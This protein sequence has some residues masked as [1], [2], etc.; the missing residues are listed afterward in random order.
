VTHD[1]RLE[2]WDTTAD[3]RL[4]NEALSGV[5]DLRALS[6]GCVTRVAGLTRLHDRSGKS[7]VLARSAQAIAVDDDAIL[8]STGSQVRRFSAAGEPRP[9]VDTG[10]GVVAM[11]RVGDRLLVGFRDGGIEFAGAESDFPTFSFEGTPASPVTVMAEG[12][13]G[14]V[15]VGYVN[16][17]LGIWSLSNGT[18]LYDTRLHGPVRHLRMRGPELQVATELGDHITL[19]VEV[20]QM[21]DC[22]LLQQVWERVPVVWRD[23]LP[24]PRPPPADHRCSRP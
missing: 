15:V 18:L 23:G 11:T 19:D 9:V 7:R 14:T 1:D 2:L 5:L 13:M 3:R 16:G 12:P 24:V 4:V 17:L 20:F 6:S 22:D 10:P 21:K 8:V